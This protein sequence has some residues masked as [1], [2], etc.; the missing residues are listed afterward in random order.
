MA[1][2]DEFGG[3]RVAD[4]SRGENFDFHNASFLV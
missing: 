4:H 3:D 1:D 2:F